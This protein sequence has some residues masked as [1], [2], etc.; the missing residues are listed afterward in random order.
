MNWIFRPMFAVGAGIRILMQLG[1]WRGVERVVGVCG[2]G[3]YYGAA[4]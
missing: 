4:A 3:A 2:D 1:I